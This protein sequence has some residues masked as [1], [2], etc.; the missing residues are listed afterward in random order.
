MGR[1][2]QLRNLCGEDFPVYCG[3]DDRILPFMACGALGAVS[4]L[5]NLRPRAVK[6]LTDA[7]LRGE[8]ARALTLQR[9]QQPLIEALFA[10]VN[11]IPVKAALALTGL[12]C[13][14][15]RLPLSPAE[16]DL[17]ERLRE[18]LDSGEEP[19]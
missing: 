16:P 19:A 14:P 10:S 9:E 7:A 3:C 13:G 2:L 5:S 18:L 1:L 11:P 12:D 15:C 6:A 4:V 17:T 8:Y